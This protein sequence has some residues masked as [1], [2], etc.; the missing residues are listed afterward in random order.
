MLNCR[1]SPPDAMT[2]FHT[3]FPG[4]DHLATLSMTTYFNCNNAAMDLSLKT[5]LF[6][7]IFIFLDVRNSDEKSVMLVPWQRQ[8]LWI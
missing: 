5:A 2:C 7:T 1:N 8:V 3:W 4:C 6:R